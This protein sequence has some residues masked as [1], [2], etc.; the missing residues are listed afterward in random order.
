[1]G[2]TPFD[3]RVERAKLPVAVRLTLEGYEPQQA[4]LTEMTGESLSLVLKKK[5]AVVKNPV[6]KNPDIKT[7][8]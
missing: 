4:S 2:Q 6:T 1:V 3:A 7:T 8:R 5:P